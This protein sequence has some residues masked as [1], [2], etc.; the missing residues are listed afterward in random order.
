MHE[1]DRRH[2]GLSHDAAGG[3]V[4]RFRKRPVEVDAWQFNGEDR[5]DWPVWVKSHP[6]TAIHYERER[7]QPL[8]ISIDTLEGEM[9]AQKGDWIIRGTAGELYPCKPDIFAEIYEAV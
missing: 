9:R 5:P 7:P 1:H 2:R 3:G 8:Y 6:D 4:S